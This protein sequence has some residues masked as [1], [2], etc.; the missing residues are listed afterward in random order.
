MGT[1]NGAMTARITRAFRQ[2]D[3]DT[4]REGIYWYEEAHR[5]AATLARA[6]DQPIEVAAAVI[7]ALS[8]L[9]SWAQNTETAAYVMRRHHEGNPAKGGALGANVAK[10]NRILSG[11]SITDV[12]G[13]ERT[14]KSGHK[15]RAFY[16]SILTR[17]TDP[18]AVCIDRHAHALAIGTRD[19][20]G[21]T[22]KRYRQVADAY[23]RATVILNREQPVDLRPELTPAQVQATT[24]LVQRRRYWSVGA[25]DPKGDP[26]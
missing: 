15:V 22:A 18:S 25:F 4:I 5:Y 13:D 14:A 17:G 11:E 3:A 7:A 26:Q 19:T 12:L 2:A 10:A 20:P 1:S 9:M 23:R 21:L 24:W 6:Y 16:R 8:P